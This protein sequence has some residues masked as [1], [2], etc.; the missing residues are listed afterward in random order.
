MIDKKK[1]KIY[2][3]F[4]KVVND[5]SNDNKKNRSIKILDWGCGKGE[6]IDYLNENNFNCVGVEISE[7][8]I[9]SNIPSKNN[10]IKKIFLINSDNKT[11]FESN[12]FDVI[13]TNQVIEH[14]SNKNSFLFEVNRILKKGG[15]SYNILPAKYRINEVHLKMPFVHWFPKNRLRKYLIFF[16]S[17]FKFNHWPECLNLEFKD[18]VN[19]YYNYSIDKTFYLDAHQLFN[20]FQNFGFCVIDRPTKIKILNN[21]FFRFLRNKFVSIEF[22]AI[23]K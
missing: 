18:K 15:I 9:Q 22:L 16:F 3:K 11:E 10:N 7:L 8:K 6:L 17:L 4:L 1:K 2:K 21:V 20:K 14:M 5:F 23:K 19:Y 12:Y 13:I